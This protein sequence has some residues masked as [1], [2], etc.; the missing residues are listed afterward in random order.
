MEDGLILSG[1][2]GCYEAPALLD[3]PKTPKPP[4][5]VSQCLIVASHTPVIPLHRT[6][7][8]LLRLPEPSTRYSITRYCVSPPFVGLFELHRV[9]SVTS[10]SAVKLNDL[11]LMHPIERASP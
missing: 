6:S 9:R 7:K 5:Q 11:V 4:L 2:L 8:A 3:S 10:A 1:G